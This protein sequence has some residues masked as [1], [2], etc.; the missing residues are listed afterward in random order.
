MCKSIFILLTESKNIMI[1]IKL[2]YYQ[3]KGLE[4]I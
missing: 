2:V 4:T 3:E 1:G